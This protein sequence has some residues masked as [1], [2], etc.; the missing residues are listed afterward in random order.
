MENE[1][2]T[3]NFLGDSIT[4]GA[5][6]NEYE[7]C[8]VELVGKKL[9]SQVRNYGIGGTR[10]AR[11]KELRG[12]MS[13]EDFLMRSKSMERDADFVFVFGGT[14]D[15]GHGDAPIGMIDSMD[16]YTFCGAVNVLISDLISWYGK[17]KIC[18]ILPLHRYDEDNVYG[19]AGIKKE[20]SIS[21]SGY[22]AILEE[23]LVK[24]GINYIHF[25]DVFPIPLTNQGD[26]F[27]VDGL[28]PNQKGHNIIA[29]RICQY[30]LGYCNK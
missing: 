21:L 3:I 24:N 22:K 12:D 15:Y 20:S 13:D 28:H 2:M 10:F 7:S 25:D 16:V 18:F 5:G 14:N 1:K 30:I 4:N 17:E 9:N 11:Q 29:E 27:T 19:E 6:A 8:Y 26:E 23:I